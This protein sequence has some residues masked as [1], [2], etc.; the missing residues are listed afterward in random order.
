MIITITENGQLNL[1]PEIQSQIQ[2]GDKYEISVIENSI[3]LKKVQKPLTWSELSRRIEQL[4]EDPEQPTLSEISDIVKEV[5][6]E[7]RAKNE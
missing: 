5:K 1:P 4:G 6:R 7:M 3:V 2:E